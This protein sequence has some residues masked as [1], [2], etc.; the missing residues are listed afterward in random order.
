VRNCAGKGTVTDEL[1]AQEGCSPRMRTLERLGDG[2]GAG[3][4]RVD[5][6]GLRLCKM[7]SVERGSGKPG[8]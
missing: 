2:G 8:R 4:A 7:C 1:R 3:E 5:G 6:G